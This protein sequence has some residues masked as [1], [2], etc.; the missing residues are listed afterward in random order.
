MKIRTKPFNTIGNFLTAA[1]MLF[2][3]ACSTTDTADAEK[4]K[5]MKKMLNNPQERVEGEYLVKLHISAGLENIEKNFRDYE[6][7]EIKSIGE[8][9]YKLKIKKDPGLEALQKIAET[10][11]MFEYIEPNYIYRVRPPG[12]KEKLKQIDK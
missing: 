11:G 10:S 7:V 6:I 8:R 9:L 1:L 2:L 12:G 4:A 3:F 5:D